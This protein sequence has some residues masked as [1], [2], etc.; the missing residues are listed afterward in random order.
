M[1]RLTL[2]LI[3]AA[4]SLTLG[5]IT[6][7]HVLKYGKAKRAAQKRANASAGQQ[8]TLDFLVR[9]SNHQFYGEASWTRVNPTGCGECAWDPTTGTLNPTPTI[10]TCYVDLN[11]RFKL[12]PRSHKVR[13][14]VP[15]RAC[16]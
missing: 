16:F 5:G 4:L 2:I 14:F 1:R 7:A 9:Q 13:A 10:E 12:R 8:T 15:S 11:V 6:D 3:A